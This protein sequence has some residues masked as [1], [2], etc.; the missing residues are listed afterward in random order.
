MGIGPAILAVAAW[1]LGLY[2]FSSYVPNLIGFFRK[3]A[4]V[5]EYIAESYGHSSIQKRQ[6]RFYSSAITLLLYLASIGAEIKFT[7]DVFSGPTGLRTGWL[8]LILSV[9][10][11]IYVSISGYRGVV[12][13]DRL[14]FWAI[15]AG[16]VAIYW[17]IFQ[18]HCH[19]WI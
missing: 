1:I 4:T 12:S 15:L 5:Q 16:V 18:Q 2:W 10:G 14:R 7:S 8:A 17:F 19:G 3:G 11:V 9:A 13:T 6:L